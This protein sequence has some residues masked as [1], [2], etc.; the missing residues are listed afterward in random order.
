MLFYNF[1]SLD[2]FI[3][4]ELMTSIQSEQEKLNKIKDLYM[5]K[6]SNLLLLITNII[7][8]TINKIDE[9]KSQE[10]YDLADSLKDS[11]EELNLICKLVDVLTTSLTDIISLYDHNIDNN[12]N[13]IKAD[14]IEY[15]K[16]S[17]ELFNKLFAF[18]NKSTSSIISALEGL[19]S[20]TSS[21][22]SK[23]KNKLKNISHNI[24]PLIKN[25]ELSHE[26][27]NTL[28]ISEKTQKAY[29]PYKYEDV[30]KLLRL[31]DILIPSEEF[32]LEFTG[33]KTAEDAAHALFEMFS[34]EVVVITQGKEGGIILQNGKIRRYPS[35]KVNAVDSNGAGD[36]FHG[37]FAYG[38]TKGFSYYDCCVFASAV[39]AL[40]CTA[41]GA[42]A[43][44]PSYNDTINFLKECGH[45]EFKE[46][47]ER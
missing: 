14:L 44:V 33:K 1:N 40:K 9:S 2:D 29:L 18:E 28:I 11:F 45:D 13:E 15:N 19:S 47:M 38:V 36:V 39:S 30:E 23:N 34:S 3:K 43:A 10:F 42:R 46:N 26:D 25:I 5:S 35:F 21:K 12:Y 37:A 22:M 8:E 32:S 24:D 27:N 7:S 41:V 4:N 16:K 6:K 20:T 17:D 31:T